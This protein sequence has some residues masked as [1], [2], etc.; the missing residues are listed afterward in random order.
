[1]VHLERLKNVKA[2]DKEVFPE[3]KGARFILI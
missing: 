1:M 3:R 2:K